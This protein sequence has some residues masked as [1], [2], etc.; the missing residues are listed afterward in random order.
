[1]LALTLLL[2]ALLLSF[3]R[4]TPFNPLLRLL[5]GLDPEPLGDVGKLVAH[6]LD[7]RRELGGP[8]NVDD[9]RGCGKPLRDGRIGRNDGPNVGGDAVAQR[10]RHA[11]RAIDADQAV[12]AEERKARLGD[13]WNV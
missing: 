1:M 6:L 7:A 4:K 2:P 9:L 12:H 3:I 13:G 10:V 5:R 11:A 8:A